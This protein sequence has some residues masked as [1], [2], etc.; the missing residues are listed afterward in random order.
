MTT[1]KD[2]F[3]NPLNSTE[4][5]STTDFEGEIR[6]RVGVDL[7]SWVEVQLSLITAIGSD[8]QQSLS[9]SVHHPHDLFM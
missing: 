3:L 5:F 6:R 2:F 4:F 9:A 8:R 7:S 1:W